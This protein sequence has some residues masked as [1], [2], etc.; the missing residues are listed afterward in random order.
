M[1]IKQ[2]NRE[3]D[4]AT[5]AYRSKREEWEFDA[6][7]VNAILAGIEDDLFNLSQQFEHLLDKKS[8]TNPANDAYR[9]KYKTIAKLVCDL[10]NEI[11]NAMYLVDDEEESQQSAM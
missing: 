2:T 6:E 9:K 10:N 8:Y 11:E 1:M 4:A 3:L 5:I 7:F